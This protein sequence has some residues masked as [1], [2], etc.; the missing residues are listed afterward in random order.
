MALAGAL[1]TNQ[2]VQARYSTSAGAF[3]IIPQN[4]WVR[5][6]EQDPSAAATVDFTSIP[7]G[8]NHLMA[9]YEFAVSSSS[10]VPFIRTYDAAGNLD[11][12]ASD[13][14]WDLFAINTVGGSSVNQATNSIINLSATVV[15]SGSVGFGGELTASN[16]QGSTYTKFD[17]KNNYQQSANGFGMM[18]Y[19]VRA[20]ADKITGVRF[21]VTTGTFTGKITLY[22]S[23]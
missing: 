1:L 18:G 8:V 17:I 16:I 19:G 6:G 11:T 7:A 22:A 14:Y 20:E 12:G 23:A 3:D 21:G 4:G 5:I 15:D 2:I 13:Y 9:R 10:A